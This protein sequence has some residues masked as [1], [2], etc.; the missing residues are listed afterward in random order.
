MLSIHSYYHYFDHR[1]ADTLGY[2]YIRIYICEQNFGLVP[3][4]R[5]VTVTAFGR[6][7]ENGNGP[8]AKFSVA[9]RTFF[10][11]WAHD[12]CSVFLPLYTYRIYTVHYGL[13]KN[14]THDAEILF[15]S[16]S[17]LILLAMRTFTHTRVCYRQSV[18]YRYFIS[19][20]F[21]SWFKYLTLIL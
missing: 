17:L 3:T 16:R 9:P 19:H 15:L 20:R 12:R 11:I 4:R 1:R 2:Y 7:P 5:R 14:K 21:T 8:K 10:F 13:L 6:P 18:R